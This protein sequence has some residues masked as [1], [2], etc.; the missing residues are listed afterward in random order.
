MTHHPA[1]LDHL[2][3][4]VAAFER[5]WDDGPV[6]DLRPFLPAADDSLYLPVLREL[7]RVDLELG[8]RQERPRPLA[9]YLREY[10]SLA[11]DRAS[12]QEIA[13]EEYRLRLQHGERPSRAEYESALGVNTEGWFEP[14]GTSPPEQGPDA[15]RVVTR[16]PWLSG[17]R[18]A[19][20]QLAETDGP[21][22]RLGEC[23]DGFVLEAELGRGAFGCVF[24][25]RQQDLVSRPV[26]LKFLPAVFVNEAHALARL[27]HTHIVPIYSLHRHG[28]LVALCMPCF[29]GQTLAALLRRLGEGAPP[30]DGA[31]LADAVRDPLAA[32]PESLRRLAKL[33]W[34]EA[35]L[36]L[37]GRLAEGLAHA[38]ERGLLHRDIKPA[39][40]LLSEEGVPLL[41]DFNLAEDIHAGHAARAGGTPA[42]MAPEY[43]ERFAGAG[44]P[45]SPATD[46]YALGLVLYQ[47]LARRLPFPVRQGPLELA[48][49]QM[50]ADRRAA[51]PPPSTYAPSVPP[52]A[53]A[54]VRRCL[55]PRPQDRYHSAGELVA[56]IERELHHQPLAHAREPLAGRWRKWRRRHARRLAGAAVAALLMTLLLLG[57]WLLIGVQK[58]RRLAAAQARQELF[59]ELPHVA[60]LLSSPDAEPGQR[61]EGLARCEAIAA[62][63]DL[64]G[65][66]ASGPLLR[67]LD[68]GARRAVR[69][70]LAEVLWLWARARLWDGDG[71]ADARRLNEQALACAGDDVPA[72]MWRQR[73]EVCRRGGDD[74]AAR[75]AEGHLSQHAATARDGYLDI[76]DRAAGGQP[77]EVLPLLRDLT[78]GP[79]ATAT[80]WL[81]LARAQADLGRLAEARVSAEVATSLEPE[82]VWAWYQ[83]GV[84]CLALRDHEAARAAFARAMALRP[85]LAEARVNLALALMG[86]D[87]PRDAEAEL[88]V[89]LEQAPEWARIYF[90]RARARHAAGDAGGAAADQREGLRREPSDEQGYLARSFARLPG[91]AKGALADLDR[92][93]AL[94]P[95]SELGL[96]NRASVLSEFLGRP[97]DA[98]ADLDRALSLRPGD[99]VARAGRAVLRGRLGQRDG[100]RAD[101]KVVEQEA[102]EAGLI[103]Q[104][105][106]AFAL[107]SK[108]SPADRAEALRLLR[109][110]F[111]A[112]AQWV[113][114]AP[115]D[116]D[117]APLAGQAEFADLLR[118]A[119]EWH[120]PAGR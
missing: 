97:K 65:D 59:S 102:T 23:I 91:D 104:A 78:R 82:H 71:L 45:A 17:A 93:L 28:D 69:Q 85:A 105:A 96:R 42:Y 110:A 31:W 7:V 98:L 33:G 101:A 61:R 77:R 20:R 106:C 53:D 95:R 8:W 120:A 60:Y 2:D 19:A 57:A 108:D 3:D 56:D 58:Q 37:V 107:V 44:P 118:K 16:S 117:L 29:G 14:E 48:L 113:A 4:Y 5:A 52:G 87:R 39:N 1:V 74:A 116:A 18:E 67:P 81:L 73:A 112:E 99:Q 30:A 103:Y 63:Y 51:T 13:Y 34:A 109:K 100:A 25:A 75:Q 26:A 32:A 119:R 94:N 11:G 49:P 83:Q 72:A 86:L 84:Y 115:R 10:P 27:Q 90:I 9:D 22:P 111:R 21:F 40:V 55:A 79:G 43:L 80:A 41:L 64:A 47:L 54:I 50:V 66:W 35:V 38:H 92:A 6:A 114:V 68:D 88:T 89:A 12:V 76:L 70:S 24:R 46:I 36:W 15:T 62:R